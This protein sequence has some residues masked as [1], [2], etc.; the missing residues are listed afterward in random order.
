MLYT[1]A[2]A[3]QVPLAYD[4]LLGFARNEPITLKRFHANGHA[5]NATI[6]QTIALQ[7]QHQKTHGPSVAILL[8]QCLHTTV[9][10]VV[11]LDC[12]PRHAC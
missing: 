2:E 4:I 1:F 11:I 8:A 5:T 9:L 7:L 12:L 3:F 10:A 6:T